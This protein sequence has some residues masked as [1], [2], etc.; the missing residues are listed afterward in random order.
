MDHRAQF[1][2]E[3]INAT[4]HELLNYVG[5]QVSLEM[6]MPKLLWL[7]KN[8]YPSWTKLWRAFDLVD[9]LTWRCTNSD[10]RSLCTV[11]CKWNFDATRM[12]WDTDFLRQIG[13]EELRC[14]DF[15]IIGN[16]FRKP[17]EPVGQGLIKCAAKEL[18]LR[19][20]TVVATGL[21][22]A[23]AGML[24]MLGCRPN[25]QSLCNGMMEFDM[26]SKLALICGSSTCHMSL[27][28][29]PCMAQGIWG[30]YKGAVLP[31]YYLN[32][33]GQ[34]ATGLLLDNLLKLHPQIEQ[35]KARLKPKE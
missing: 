7:R 24:G 13:L 11:V 1:E 6:E 19:P 9:F 34:S 22:D 17:G 14:N 15:E 23:H 31:D 4:K 30:P 8:A 32:E 2:A 18:K 29:E 16:E 33:A 27:T 26:Q 20:G 35:I 5:G 21:I 28:R 25:V 12:R 3:Q 10:S